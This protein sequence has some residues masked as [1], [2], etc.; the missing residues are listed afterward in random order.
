MKDRDFIVNGVR[1]WHSDLI[2]IEGLV[3]LDTQETVDKPKVG[4]ESLRT[5][6]GKSLRFV[7]A[8]V[9]L[10]NWAPNPNT[11]PKPKPEPITKPNPELQTQTRAQTRTQNTRNTIRISSVPWTQIDFSYRDGD[12]NV[13]SPD[14]GMY[15]TSRPSSVKVA[16]NVTVT[17]TIRARRGWG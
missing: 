6:T 11:N 17:A 9:I 7:R 12:P 16:S 15:L 10:V 13:D 8:C 2:S 5:Q 3:T 14:R 4:D 1:W